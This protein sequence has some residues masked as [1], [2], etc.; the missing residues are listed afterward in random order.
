L[1]FAKVG[2]NVFTRE[3]VQREAAALRAWGRAPRSA[4]LGAP[5]LIDA[6]P[7]NDLELSVVTPLPRMVR[8]HPSR[9]LPPL[10]AT[11]AVARLEGSTTSTLADSDY[12]EQLRKR[13]QAVAS[14]VDGS[15]ERTMRAVEVITDRAGDRSVEIASWH[16]DW[17]PWNLSWDGGRLYAIDWEHSGR[18]PLGFD[19]LHYHFATAFYARRV[20]T[21]EAATTLRQ[22]TRRLEGLGVDENLGKTLAALYLLELLARASDAS[23][24]GAGMNPRLLPALLGTIDATVQD[25]R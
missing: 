9:R 15:E 1:G 3:L 2:W 18:A 25:I 7:W 4:V 22:G 23:R 21:N 13:L 10:Q 8:R 12:L 14:V 5:G 24:G 20:D 16:G 6:G 17:T 19:I 11:S